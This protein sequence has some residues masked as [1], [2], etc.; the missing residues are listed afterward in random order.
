MSV[1]RY[2]WEDPSDT[3]SLRFY[4]E[5]ST[6]KALPWKDEIYAAAR[7]IANRTKKP[8][9]V[10]SSGGIDSEVAC[11]AFFDQGINFSVLTLAHTENTNFHDINYAVRWCRARNV[12][13]EIVRIDM[14]AFLTGEVE[15]YA[16]K[17]PALH[18]FRYFQIKLMET[19]E[20][21][22]GFAVLAGGEQLYNARP[23][24]GSL[25]RDDL[26]LLFTIGN[27][28]PIEWCKD[29]STDHEPYFYFSTPELC[30][31]FMRLPL[32][33]FA[34]ENPDTVFTHKANAYTLK[35]IVYQSIWPDL[36]VRYKAD[37]FEKIK[38]LVQESVMRMREICGPDLPQFQLPV[39][40]FE[41]QLVPKAL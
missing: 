23:K 37:G 12:R 18:P 36:E 39:R 2:A 21:M 19:V 34:L 31:S 38:P 25:T 32:V 24:E 22:G 13:H 4:F 41:K 30:L 1:L 35:R 40:E 14:P 33:N 7:T 28:A 17:Y 15:T 3:K 6:R 16:R 10:C 26:Y 5:S 9:W 8:I 29:N 20:R 27:I 11:R